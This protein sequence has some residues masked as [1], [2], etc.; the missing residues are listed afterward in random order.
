VTVLTAVAKV[1]AV[2]LLGAGAL[3]ANSNR[4]LRSERVVRGVMRK[5]RFVR[6][7]PEAHLDV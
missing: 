4:N 2:P 1:L 7:Y 3:V 5:E 6:K